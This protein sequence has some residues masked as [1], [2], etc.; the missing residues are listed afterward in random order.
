ML[1]SCHGIEVMVQKGVFPGPCSLYDIVTIPRSSYVLGQVTSPREHGP[2]GIEGCCASRSPVH[3]PQTQSVPPDPPVVKGE[4][5]MEGSLK[6]SHEGRG[7]RPAEPSSLGTEAP[8][9]ALVLCAGGHVAGSLWASYA[10]W[11]KE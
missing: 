5:I 3:V 9:P 7:C 4:A 10:Q 8:D 1:P 11:I 2:R 6:D